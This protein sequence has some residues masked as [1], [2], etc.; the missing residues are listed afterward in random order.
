[1]KRHKKKRYNAKS[2]ERMEWE[3][4]GVTGRRAGYPPISTGLPH[5]RR[6]DAPCTLM[7]DRQYR[8]GGN[9]CERDG[10]LG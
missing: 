6:P 2:K 8:G 5:S 4:L 10:A 1:M 9:P 3:M 7:E